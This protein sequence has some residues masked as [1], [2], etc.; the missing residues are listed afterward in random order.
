MSGSG[1]CDDNAKAEA[2]FST[3]KANACQLIRFSSSRRLRAGSCSSISRPT[4]RNKRLH[5]ALGYQAP[6]QFEAEHFKKESNFFEENVRPS[7][8]RSVT[9]FKRVNGINGRGPRAAWEEG[10]LC[11]ITTL[12]AV[13]SSEPILMN[14]H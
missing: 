13:K 8:L 4:T 12:N 7:F 9:K 6:G 10:R 3:L 14:A 1:N 2:F 5:S 11:R